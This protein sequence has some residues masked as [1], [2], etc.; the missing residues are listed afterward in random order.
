MEPGPDASM[1]VKNVRQDPVSPILTGAVP[2]MAR[3]Y[4]FPR[5][6]WDAGS[7]SRGQVMMVDLTLECSILGS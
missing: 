6:L 7:H 5:P 3:S 4:I 2:A 1:N